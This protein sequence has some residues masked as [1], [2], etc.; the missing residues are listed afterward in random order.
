MSEKISLKDRLR[1]CRSEKEM[2]ADWAWCVKTSW[3]NVGGGYVEDTHLTEITARL[4]QLNSR[5]YGCRA[6]LG[7]LLTIANC[8]GLHDAGDVL[9]DILR[10]SKRHP[11]TY[12][13]R[14]YTRNV[15]TYR[16]AR[17]KT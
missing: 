14:Q 4:P 10:S 16:G 11:F 2:D 17:G 7:V 6:Q 12:D 13:W 5:P 15:N 1:G 8:I 3:E 9:E